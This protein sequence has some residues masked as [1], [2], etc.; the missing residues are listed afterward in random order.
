MRAVVL[1]AGNGERFKSVSPLP[2]PFI[3]IHRPGYGTAMMIE[4]VL[5]TIPFGIERYMAVPEM[6]M[7][8][9]PLARYIPIRETRSPVHTLQQV[10]ER[11]EDD[12]SLLLLDCDT[13]VDER[14]LDRL[15]YHVMYNGFPCAVAVTSDETDENMSRVD[16]VPH[17]TRFV[18]KQMISRWGIVSARAFNSTSRLRQ[19]LQSQPDGPLTPLLG[20]Y[21]SC[22]AYMIRRRWVDWGTPE[23]L[24]A[25]GAEVAR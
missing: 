20:L 14:D 17:P 11:M 22:Y 18:E 3:P 7:L 19:L 24:V 2:K 8:Y 1:A 10:L 12:S 16:T 25:S 5:N 15:V 6:A 13:L 21:G 23:R 9:A 4:H